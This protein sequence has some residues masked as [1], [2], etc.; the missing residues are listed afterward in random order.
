MIDLGVTGPSGN[1]VFTPTAVRTF[2]SEAL[3]GPV[4]LTPAEIETANTH[5]ASNTTLEQ[6][7]DFYVANRGDNT[8]VRMRQ[9][10]TVVALRRVLVEGQPLDNAT[11]NGLA[12]A[13]DGRGAVCS[14]TDR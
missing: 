12:T 5:W 14:S 7:A 10:G 1:E 13:S 6:G 11:L 9:D 3:N 4:D 2:G 8:I